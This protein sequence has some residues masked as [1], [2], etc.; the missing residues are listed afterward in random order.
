MNMH[1]I[2]CHCVA[3]SIVSFFIF[4]SCP[5]RRHTMG[6]FRRVRSTC[7]LQLHNYKSN[8]IQTRAIA[9]SLAWNGRV[10]SVCVKE[11]KMRVQCRWYLR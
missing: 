8:Q 6:A 4:F 1:G 10:S 5:I 11:I 3:R 7:K 9:I 2:V